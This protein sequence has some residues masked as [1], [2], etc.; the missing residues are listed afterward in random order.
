MSLL[1]EVRLIVTTLGETDNASLVARFFS[2]NVTAVLLS[3]HNLR[4]AAKSR[5]HNSNIAI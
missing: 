4:R 2:V 1:T 5:R 3:S